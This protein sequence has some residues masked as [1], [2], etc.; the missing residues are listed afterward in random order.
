MKINEIKV[1]NLV[2]HKDFGE[3]IIFGID[4]ETVQIK[5]NNSDKREWVDIKDLSGVP[6]TKELI[7]KY[8]FEWIIYYQANHK[9]GF[10]FD[11][12]ESYKGGYSLSTFKKEVILVEK[13]EYLHQLQN[14][15]FSLMNKELTEVN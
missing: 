10:K 5:P 3:C 11:L 2:I 8:G 14:V 13:M 1:N 6:L 9:V 12:N 4:K 7:F 15:Y